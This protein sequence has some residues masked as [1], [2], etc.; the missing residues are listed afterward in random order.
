MRSLEASALQCDVLKIN[1]ESVKHH[2]MND[3]TG[4][5]D[6]VILVLLRP[7]I[8]SVSADHPDVPDAPVMDDSSE[9][10]PTLPWLQL[11]SQSQHQKERFLKESKGRQLLITPDQLPV[12]L[13]G[14]GAL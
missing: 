1:Y 9:T 7:C 10:F 12:P 3:L 11:L 14:S 8:S 6:G 2:R 4:V 5:E 13:P